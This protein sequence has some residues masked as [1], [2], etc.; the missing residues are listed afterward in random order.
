MDNTENRKYIV[1]LFFLIIGV[2]FL[3]RLGYMQ[4]VDDQWKDRASQIS[5][6][7][8]VTYPARGIVFDRNN[9][10]LI[11]NEIY[12]DLMV[13][14]KKVK[15]ID[16]FAFAKLIGISIEEYS[17]RMEKAK[18]YSYR[19]ASEFEKQ[20]S[21]DDYALIGP[22]LYKYPGFFEQERTLRKYP[23][24]IAPH[25]LGYMNEV[26]A[27]DIK[28]NPYY[29]SRDYIGRSGIEKQYE[30]VLRGERGVKYL[31]Q[32]A[33][34]ITTGSYKDGKLDTAAIT[35]KNITLGIDTDLQA[36]GELLMQNKLGSIVAI[37]PS[38]GEILAMVSAPSYN[39][40]LLVG[41][42]LGK[43]YGE[44]QKDSLKPLLNR[45][46]GSIY[47]PGSTFKLVMALVGM[48]E[49]V[50]TENSGFPCTKSLVGCHNHPSAQTVEQA[51][52]MSCN[53]YF[54]YVVRRIIQQGKH[55]SQFK[56]AAKGLDIWAKYVH[57]FGL[58]NK[59]E[60][61]LGG[62]A[63]GLIPDKAYYDKIYGEYRWAYSTI[64]SICIGQ[65]EVTVSPFEMANLAAIMANRGYYYHPHFIKDI[66]G[67]GVPLKYT[68]KNFTMVDT[69][70]FPIVVNGM[71]KVVNEAGGTARR[72]R[73]DS[74]VV[75]GKTGT[76][77]NPHGEDH[78]IFIAF[79]PKDNP[80]I[81][82]SVYIENA[83]FGGTWA[84]P[85]A[86]LLI[87]QY[88]NDSISNKKKEQ[89]ILDANLIQ[90]N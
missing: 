28:K 20:I 58:G 66:G 8:I 9:N 76:A 79:A 68:E 84:A 65:G 69:S 42:N 3:I 64:Y 25:L 46:A 57:S 41:R 73:I 52:K 87:E 7:K 39:P 11:T 70:Y 22:E 21:P 44:L 54:Y 51:V 4:L 26:N 61:D 88:L 74:L 30:K 31:L 83:G 86:S 34:G 43:N 59:N 49:G 63:R 55:N 13:I 23:K 90:I 71:E 67:E 36:Y 27:D 75:C 37:E 18:D 1:S 82:I 85:I 48:Q 35:G 53:P 33:I 10:K 5:E 45:S 47:P 72:A 77:Q 14:P 40:N 80:K 81:A 32:D 29:K 60:T 6:N 12:Y 2:I 56:D 62:M 89:R 78:S 17:E 16:S 24:K 15:D 38:S 50:I 19:K